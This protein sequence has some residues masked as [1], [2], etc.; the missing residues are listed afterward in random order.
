MINKLNK[1]FEDFGSIP[2][3]EVWVGIEAAL[4]GQRRK[5]RFI[6]I[7][8]PAT[9]AGIIVALFLAIQISAP[10]KTQTKNEASGRSVSKPR[11]ETS[12]DGRSVSKPK[13]EKSKDGI[14]SVSTGTNPKTETPLIS[15]VSTAVNPKTEHPLI[16]SAL[17]DPDPKTDL[18]ADSLAKNPV[19]IRDSINDSSF[20]E[21]TSVKSG[22]NPEPGV[23]AWSFSLQAGTWDASS[24]RGQLISTPVPTAEP[25]TGDVT[26]SFVPTVVSNNTSAPAD[27][28]TISVLKPLS[29]RANIAFTGKR[30]FVYTAGLNYDRMDALYNEKQTRFRSVGMNLG[31]GKDFALSERFSLTPVLLLNYDRFVHEKADHSSV[32]VASAN[33]LRGQQ[34]SFQLDVNL[35]FHLTEK[36][37]LFLSPATKGYVYQSLTTANGPILRRDWWNGLYFG[38]KCNF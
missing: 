31:I 3:P 35:S 23:S 13:I 24:N 7:F 6:W 29:W 38:W 28:D 18:P 8:L 21:I 4:N 26:S 12:K 33:P 22:R 5:R 2:N 16:S 19:A 36:Q 32:P 37:S 34:L 25:L 15:S 17:S 9:A 10:V 1:N 30:G 14:Y 11:I 20:S 27:T